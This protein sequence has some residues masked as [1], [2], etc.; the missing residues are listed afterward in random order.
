MAARLLLR[1]E[2]NRDAPGLATWFPYNAQ[3]EA[4][5]E[6]NRDVGWVGM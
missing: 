3:I 4:I 2:T 5:V 6:K 1:T